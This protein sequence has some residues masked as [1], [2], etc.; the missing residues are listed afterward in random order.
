[1]KRLLILAIIALSML[2][3]VSAE[4]DY[5]N[6]DYYGVINEPGTYVLSEDIISPK[7]G[8]ILINTSN[9]VLDGDNHH[10]ICN[11]GS[12]E[13][14]GV[15]IYP[16]G[17]PIENITIKNAVFKNWTSAIYSDDDSKNVTIR[18]CEFENNTYFLDSYGI[19]IYFYL[20]T[21]HE[22]QSAESYAPLASPKL[23]YTYGGTE[24]TYRLGNYYYGYEGTDTEDEGVYSGVYELDSTTDLYAL[25]KTPENYIITETLYPEVDS[26]Y[27]GALIA[28][29]FALTNDPENYVITDAPVT[30][31]TTRSSGSS[32]GRSYDSDIS[33]EIDSKVIKNFV[34]SAAVIFGNE[35]DQQYAEELR[36]RIQNAENYKISGNAVIVGGPLSNGFAREYNDQFEMP[37]SNDYPGENKG[38]IQ[39]LK[40]QDNSGKIVKSYTIV[41]I[42]GSDRLGTQAAL[43]YFKTLDELPEGP[44]T[45][46]WTANGPVLVE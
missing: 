36:E 26:E 9:V 45:V 33:D 7:W 34:S 22:N 3:S 43:E 42:A 11:N 40:I 15:D 16:D 31:T 30:T 39:V 2:V 10:I 6:S 32:G 17:H 35:I 18:N 4:M 25:I 29:I 13:T 14:Y 27:G 21:I 28:D 8:G 38:V 24:Y 46:K 20:N 44:I 23:V 37:I 5:N 41:Y 19:E 1:M 12:E